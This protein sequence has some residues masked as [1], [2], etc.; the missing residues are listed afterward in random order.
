MSDWAWLKESKD[1]KVLFV[2]GARHIR[3][4][5]DYRIHEGSRCK[6]PRAS[7]SSGQGHMA[8]RVASLASDLG[9]QELDWVWEKEEEIEGSTWG[10][11][12]ARKTRRGGRNPRLA[13]PAVVLGA[14]G[15]HGDGG[16]SVLPGR[17]ARAT[18][19]QLSLAKLLVAA[20]SSGGT[21][22]RQI[23]DGVAERWRW[24]LH[25]PFAP[26]GF[27][28]QLT[29]G[30]IYINSRDSVVFCMARRDSYIL[31]LGF[32]GKLSFQTASPFLDP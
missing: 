29:E 28:S 11:S 9:N 31:T 7:S 24:V 15:P 25:D 13:A 32:L 17:R 8:A 18:D 4:D 1:S 3:R 5:K 30:L 26:E 12:P 2:K 22:R 10:C 16:A 27:V 23:E 14:T 6:T 21:P 20:A 19:V